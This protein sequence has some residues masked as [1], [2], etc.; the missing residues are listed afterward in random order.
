[1]EVEVGRGVG[2]GWDRNSQLLFGLGGA[3]VNISG[4]VCERRDGVRGG[5]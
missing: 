3:M 2:W 1:M 5:V 4:V